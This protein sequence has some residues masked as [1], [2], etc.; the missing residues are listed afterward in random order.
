MDNWTGHQV[1][2]RP[3]LSAVRSLLK[4]TQWWWQRSRLEVARDRCGHHVAWRTAA[5]GEGDVLLS[6]E[7]LFVRLHVAPNSRVKAT[8]FLRLQTVHI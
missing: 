5:G 6:L 3:A 8:L 7:L 2:F 4:L 1:A